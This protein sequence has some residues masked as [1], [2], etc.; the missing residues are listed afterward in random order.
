M[1]KGAAQQSEA[2]RERGQRR[3]GSRTASAGATRA[4]CVV[5]GG[6]IALWSCVVVCVCVCGCVGV[7]A[8][9]KVLQLC[10]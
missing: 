9:A 3:R 5:K 1:G 2:R 7:R 8:R 4:P 6:N 10:V